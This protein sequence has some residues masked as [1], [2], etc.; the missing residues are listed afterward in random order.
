MTTLQRTRRPGDLVTLFNRPLFTLPDWLGDQLSALEAEIPV[1]EFEADGELVIRAELPG[2][3]PERD[4]EVTIQDG[5]LHIRAERRREEKEERPDYRRQEI[6]YGAFYRTIPL[7]AGCGEEDVKATYADGILTIR[8][9]LE[10][11][12]KPAATRVPVTRK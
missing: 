5:M 8:L 11:A 3:D 2:I 9:P 6:R 4:V 10:E 12:E 1:E 7:P